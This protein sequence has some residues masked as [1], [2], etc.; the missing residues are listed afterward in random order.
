MDEEKLGQA[1]EYLSGLIEETSTVSVERIYDRW[2]SETELEDNFLISGMEVLYRN[3]AYGFTVD[4]DIKASPDYDGLDDSNFGDDLDFIEVEKVHSLND[5]EVKEFSDHFRRHYGEEAEPEV[6]D[7]GRGLID[8]QDSI[9][10]GDRR[11]S[12]QVRRIDG[13]MVKE[14]SIGMKAP[15]VDLSEDVEYLMADIIEDLE[16]EYLAKIK[17]EEDQRFSTLKERAEIRN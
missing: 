16:D 7:R 2:P 1:V 4:R 5:A 6:L 10:A 14:A 15:I 3:G 9:S 13:D 8:V 17:V 11:K 12:Y